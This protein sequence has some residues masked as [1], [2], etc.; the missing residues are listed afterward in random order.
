MKLGYLALPL[1]L[2]G[3]SLSAEVARL[4]TALNRPVQVHKTAQNQQHSANAT[5]KRTPLPP[6]AV[7]FPGIETSRPSP[8]PD[9]SAVQLE[10]TRCLATCPAYTV[11]IR[12]DGSFSYTGVYGVER[13]G[14]HRGHIEVGRLRQVFR[15]IDEIGF[16]ELE[17]RYLS[18][19]PDNA[20]AITTVVQA[21][22]R[23]TVTN[24]ANSG[25]ATLWALEQ[26]IDALVESATWDAGGGLK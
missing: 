8:L 17:P 26:L 11:T 13:L 1:A 14:E 3:S 7:F 12:A 5:G 9:I 18:P 2:F 19:Y 4:Q 6:G 24:Y 21:G 16:R 23:K 22:E 15:Y 20:T 10:R 25:P